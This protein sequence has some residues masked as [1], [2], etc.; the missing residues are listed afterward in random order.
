MSSFLYFARFVFCCVEIFGNLNLK[1]VSW[2]EKMKIAKRNEKLTKHQDKNKKKEKIKY[3]RKTR[4]IY[5]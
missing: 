5:A 3:S 4:V 2:D 1:D